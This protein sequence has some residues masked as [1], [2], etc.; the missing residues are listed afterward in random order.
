MENRDVLSWTF[1]MFVP[2]PK[3]CWFCHHSV[4]VFY[5]CSNLFQFWLVV[6]MAKLHLVQ[7]FASTKAGHNWILNLAQGMRKDRRWTLRL[8]VKDDCCWQMHIEDAYCWQ[9]SCQGIEDGY[10]WQTCYWGCE[11]GCSG[12]TCCLLPCC[13]ALYRNRY[14]LP[15]RCRHVYL[16]GG[17]SGKMPCLSRYLPFCPII[18]YIGFVNRGALLGRL[19]FY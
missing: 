3:P 7:W 9:T 5:W 6:V 4:N 17:Y 10:L 2:P 14:L 19:Q 1:L 13:L 16:G 18:P 12:Q 15:C 11:N 8:D